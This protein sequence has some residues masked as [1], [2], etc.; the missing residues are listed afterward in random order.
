M[1]EDLDSQPT[2]HSLLEVGTIEMHPSCRV[3]IEAIQRSVT[4]AMQSELY[5]KTASSN[6]V[7][8]C[9]SLSRMRMVMHISY[10]LQ[11]RPGSSEVMIGGA[12]C[13]RIGTEGCRSDLQ[14]FAVVPSFVPAECLTCRWY[15]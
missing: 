4:I 2:I 6:S 7:D 5:C 8:S 1:S 9:L 15:G 3:K 14:A 11:L 10:I 13:Q 12:R